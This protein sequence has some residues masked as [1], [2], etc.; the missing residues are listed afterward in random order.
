MPSF[1]STASMKVFCYFL[2]TFLFELSS[3]P[4]CHASSSGKL[5]LFAGA[6]SKP[7]T[8][9]VVHDFQ[10][11]SGILVEA[12]FGGSGFVLSQMKLSKR[13]DIYFPG[14]SDFMELAKR[15]RLVYPESEKIVVYLVPAIN[16]QK[17]NPKGIKSLKDLTRKGIR[18]AIAN[19]EMVCV[20]TYAVE[21][22]E[23]NLNPLEKDALKRNLVNYTESCEKTANVI[24]LKAVDAVIGWRVFQYWD[25]ERIETV[26]LKPEEIPRI[27]YIPIAISKFAQDRTLAQTFVDFILSPQGKSIFRKYNYLMDLQE[28]RQFTKPDAPVGGEY[29]LPK[30]WRTR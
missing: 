25:P 15:E 28:A 26:L 2:L 3:F 24:S 30:E 13:G 1:R 6:A 29:I 17:G 8:E 20:G 9:K 27:G 16:V 11:K 4:Q 5:L 23:K 7:P 21:I 12:V 10:K 22:I 14:S 19:P 18:I